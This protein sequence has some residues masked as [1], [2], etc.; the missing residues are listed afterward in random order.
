MWVLAI[1]ELI[2]FEPIKKES[3]LFQP[4]LLHRP[5]VLARPTPSSV[6][7]LLVA[8][9]PG[10]PVHAAFAWIHIPEAAVGQPVVKRHNE[11]LISFLV[12]RL[13]AVLGSLFEVDLILLIHVFAQVGALHF[14]SCHEYCRTDVLSTSMDVQPRHTTM[15]AVAVRERNVV[16]P[17]DL[18]VRK[19]SA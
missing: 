13:G 8:F 9:R 10:C 4:R 19:R 16:A 6:L 18:I 2:G 14:A 17:Y 7:S 1:Q 15:R 12:I 5:P 3:F 11:W